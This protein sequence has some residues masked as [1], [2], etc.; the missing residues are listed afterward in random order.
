M[1]NT[2][3]SD[4]WYGFKVMLRFLRIPMIFRPLK[5]KKMQS[6]ESIKIILID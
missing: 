4:S 2:L 3:I 5:N 6:E 1:K